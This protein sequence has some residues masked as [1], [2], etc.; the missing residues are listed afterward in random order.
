MV[1]S[2]VKVDGM[3]LAM[4]MNMVLSLS[5]LEVMSAEYSFVCADGVESGG[6]YTH[7]I[8]ASLDGE[9]LRVVVL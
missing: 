3:P 2:A 6:S 8:V 9:G 5:I 7:F 4:L 1:C